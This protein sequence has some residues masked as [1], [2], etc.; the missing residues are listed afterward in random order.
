MAVQQDFKELCELFNSLGVEYVIVGGHALAFH[1]A[2][3]FTGDIDFF[4]HPSTENSL[5]ILQALE[6][7]GFGGA[8]ITVEDLMSPGR[9]IQMGVVPVR[10]DIINSLSGVSWDEVD[11][12]KVSGEYGGVP[13]HFIGRT[14][15]IA[16]KL[17]A[18]RKKDLADVEA[19]QLKPPRRKS[20]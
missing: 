6:S 2:P 1:G 7:F 15:Y 9:I 11:R 10:I 17:A 20:D 5:R 3:R 19:L 14:E 12:G 18:G 4:V 13:V 16:N 8:G